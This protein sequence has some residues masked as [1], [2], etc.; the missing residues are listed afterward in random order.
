[1][2]IFAPVDATQS[3]ATV[4]AIRDGISNGRR[5][6]ASGKPILACVMADPGR[7]Q[8]LD[9]GGEHIPTYTFPENAVRAL[10]KVAAYA[11]WRTQPP[12]LLWGFDDVYP[13]EAQ[14][15]CRGAFESRGEDWLT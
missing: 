7:P 9:A 13:E 5:A 11:A 1:I 15:I 6:G 3:A 8:T 10:S 12:G 4:A 2:V 14:S